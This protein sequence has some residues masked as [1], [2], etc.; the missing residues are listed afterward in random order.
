M[1]GDHIGV[2]SCKDSSP[3]VDAGCAEGVD[4]QPCSILLI[5]VGHSESSL[6]DFVDFIL[7]TELI[8]DFVIVLVIDMV[9]ILNAVES[10]EVVGRRMKFDA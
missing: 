7:D 4:L 1:E 6:Q 5:L 10:F 9:L 8:F 2:G 3:M